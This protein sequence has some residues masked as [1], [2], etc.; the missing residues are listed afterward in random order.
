MESTAHQERSNNETLKNQPSPT[1]LVTEVTRKRNRELGEISKRQW[2][3]DEEGEEGGEDL[4]ASSSSSSSSSGGGGNF[5]PSPPSSKKMSSDDAY[6][7]RDAIAYC[8]KCLGSPDEKDWARLDVAGDIMNRLFIKSNSRT[9]TMNV[10]RACLEAKEEGEDYSATTRQNRNKGQP[11]KINDD[12]RDPSACLY[13]RLSVTEAR[14]WSPLAS[15]MKDG[16][17]AEKNLSLSPQYQRL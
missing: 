5:R 13:G 7:R 3:Q 14:L 6:K 10:M 4:Q 17:I 2:F 1:F 15:S 12:P 8:F 11:R 16:S 9:A